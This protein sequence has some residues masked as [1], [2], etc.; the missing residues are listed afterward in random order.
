MSDPSKPPKAKLMKTSKSSMK[1]GLRDATF[2]E[3]SPG[4]VGNGGDLSTPSGHDGGVNGK[5]AVLG[6]TSGRSSSLLQKTSAKRLKMNAKNSELSTS[7]PADGQLDLN[8]KQ[9]DTQVL[10]AKVPKK[11]K[12]SSPGVGISRASKI[13]HTMAKTSLNRVDSQSGPATNSEGAACPRVGLEHSCGNL[14]TDRTLP[15]R[16]IRK[17]LPAARVGDGCSDDDGDHRGGLP[18]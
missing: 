15:M 1:K 12:K 2:S 13:S 18:W 5:E 4:L 16:N 8:D 3:P 9:P 6:A 7:A 10:D 14:S 17:D 11:V